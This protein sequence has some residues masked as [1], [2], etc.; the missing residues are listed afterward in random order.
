MRFIFKTDYH[1]DIRLAPHSGHVF[2]YGLL[3]ALVIAAPFA[4]DEYYVGQLTQVG[5]MAIAGVGLMV[6]TGYTGLVSLGHAAFFGVGAY[7][8]AVLLGLGVPFFVTMPAAAVSAAAVGII[9][10]IPAL[11][12]AGIYLAIATFAFALIVEEIMGRWESVTNGYTGLLVPSI[13]IGDF[14]LSSGLPFYFLTMAILVLVILLVLN[15]LRAPTGRAMVAIRDSEI[16][17]QSMGVNLAVVKTTAFAVSA[18]ITGLAGA[19]FAHKLGF[20]S[21][22]SFT[23]LQSIELLVLV[24]V[25]GIGSLH[26]AVFGAIF[27]LALPQALAIMKDHLPPAIGE[28]PGFEPLI[29]GLILIFFILFEP[30]GIYGRWLKVKLY[31][32]LFPLYKKATFKRQKSYMKSERLR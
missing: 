15:L 2:W 10:G 32:Q 8:E 20:L 24:I 30:F 18:G 23:I 27:V 11:R 17:A 9:V 6:L 5:I 3:L 28:Q 21:P 1:Q 22:E 12:L 26:G 29:F 19:L 25:G 31:F 13:D 16:S 4:L 14:S 7:A